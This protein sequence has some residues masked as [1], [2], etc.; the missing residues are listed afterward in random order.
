MQTREEAEMIETARRLGYAVM[1][2][3]KLRRELAQ[4]IA[5]RMVNRTGE[6]VYQ[7]AAFSITNFPLTVLQTV[8]PDYLLT[9][10]TRET[11]TWTLPSVSACATILGPLISDITMCAGASRALKT[12]SERWS[13]V[14]A[15][16]YDLEVSSVKSGATRVDQTFF[17]FLYVL[18]DEDGEMHKPKNGKRVELLLL[19]AVETEIRQ[20]VLSDAIAMESIG[21]PLSAGWLTSMGK[22][23]EAA[24]VVALQKNTLASASSSVGGEK[25]RKKPRSEPALLRGGQDCGGAGGW[26]DDRVPSAIGG[27]R[28]GVGAAA[29]HRPG[30]RPLGELGAA[31]LRQEHGGALEVEVRGVGLRVGGLSPMFRPSTPTVRSNPYPYRYV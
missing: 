26:Q 21:V 19:P 15:T 29:D 13:R 10:D 3:D 4:S 6:F 16:I 22:T 30:G 20:Q 17:N 24:W 7:S 1:P 18:M 27:V 31:C 28:A 11:K 9:T 8:F 23:A 12:A 14:I 25:K 2:V 5:S